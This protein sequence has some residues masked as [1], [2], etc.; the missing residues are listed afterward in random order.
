MS[1]HSSIESYRQGVPLRSWGPQGAADAAVAELN[2]KAASAIEATQSLLKGEAQSSE[3]TSTF[4]AANF[5]A[6]LSGYEPI[7]VLAGQPR[8]VPEVENLL[9]RFSK[10]FASLSH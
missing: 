9:T 3:N 2:L 7:F 8:I 1:I 10:H 6:F 5:Y 4:G